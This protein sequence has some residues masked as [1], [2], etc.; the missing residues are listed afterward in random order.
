MSEQD[1]E[2]REIFRAAANAEGKSLR[3]WCKDNGIVYETIIGREL[4][5]VQPLS[6]VHDHSGKYSDSCPVCSRV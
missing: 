2:I 1:K 4:P 3:Q 5:S 6:S